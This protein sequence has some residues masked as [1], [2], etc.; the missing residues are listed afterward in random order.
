[1][2]EALEAVPTRPAGNVSQRLIDAMRY[3]GR[4]EGD[5]HKYLKNL[6]VASIEADPAFS[7]LAIEE[8]W[9]GVTDET[10]WRKP[11]VAARYLGLA[12]PFY[13]T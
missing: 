1:M 9:W 12:T 13:C 4:K 7:D 8:R 6:V 11:D 3:N 2:W 10:K 5:G